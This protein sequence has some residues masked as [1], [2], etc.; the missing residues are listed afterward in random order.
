MYIMS[1]SEY[2]SY[3]TDD[4]YEGELLCKNIDP[5]L[6]KLMGIIIEENK[7][8]TWTPPAF[9]GLSNSS[10]IFENDFEKIKQKIKNFEKL[11]ND[12]LEKIKG[13]SNENKLIIISIY[14]SIIR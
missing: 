7:T 9:S 12:E 14:N 10:P 5:N 3:S 11:T 2:S 13:M 4:E 8:N 1:D 6:A